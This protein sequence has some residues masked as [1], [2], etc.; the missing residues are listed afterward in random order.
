M[1]KP[2][3]LA[4][5]R[6]HQQ[7]IERASVRHRNRFFDDY[8]VPTIYDRDK[9][10]HVPHFFWK[11]GNFSQRSLE[12]LID[13]FG[14]DTASLQ[15]EAEL[16]INPLRFA[17][18]DPSKRKRGVASG[19]TPPGQRITNGGWMVF[20][21]EHDG[22]DA[23]SLE[24]QLDW[25]AGKPEECEFHK[26]HEAMST[27][28]D[29]RGYSTAFS[30]NKSLHIHLVFDTRHLSKEVAEKSKWANAMWQ[31]DVPDQVLQEL[32]RSTWLH[33]ATRVQKS[34]GVNIK[35]DDRLSTYIQKRR[36]PWGTRMFLAGEKPNIHGFQPGDFIEQ[37]VIQEHI[38]SRAPKGSIIT[39]LQAGSAKTIMEVER[40]SQ[41]KPSQ[42]IVTLGGEDLLLDELR[43]YLTECGWG[44]YPEP[45]RIEYLEPYNYVY[46]KNHAGDENPTTYVRGDYRM[47]APS[48]RDAHREQLFLPNNYTLDET[49]DVIQQRLDVRQVHPILSAKQQSKRPKKYTT[50]FGEGAVSRDTARGNLS[51]IL[52]N[53]ADASGTTLVQAPEGI[54]KTYALMQHV[55]ELRWDREADR[56]HRT[57]QRGDDTWSPIPGFICFACKSYEQANAKRD[58]FIEI[59]NGNTCA[60]VIKSLSKLYEE[61]AGELGIKP[62]KRKQAGANGSVSFLHAVKSMQP[63]VYNRMTELRDEMWMING[64][65]MFDPTHTVVFCV[66]SLLKNWPHSQISKAFLHPGF[67]DDFNQGGIKHC[68]REMGLYQ[69]IYDE[70]GWEDLVSIDSSEDV[71]AAKKVAKSV[72]KS[73]GKD[74]KDSGLPAQVEAYNLLLGHK[75]SPAIKFDDCNR[76]NQIGY[77]KRDKLK[78]DA[79]RFPFGKGTDEFNIYAKRSGTYYI[80]EHRW[81]SNLGCPVVILTTEDLPRCIASSITLAH[82]AE[83]QLKLAAGQKPHR[84]ESQYLRTMNLTDTPHLFNELVPVYFEKDARAPDKKGRTSVIDMAQDLLESG[85]DFVISN[86]LK[87]ID[88]KYEDQVCSHQAA[89]GRNDLT[90]MT[91]ATIITY[92]S[93]GEYDQLCILG[94]KFDLDD[95]VAMAM[96]DT[97][98]QDL[99]RNLGLRSTPGQKQDMHMVFIKSSLYRDLN[100]FQGATH[101]RYRLYHDYLLN[102]IS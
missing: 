23:A 69:V 80:K 30:G 67:P 76:I 15:S 44:Q 38:L 33:L 17:D 22:V 19:Y 35:F 74:W 75:K 8:I 28:S 98:F 2:S 95:P 53:V 78:V 7:Q 50:S 9:D 3:D 86:N 81:W 94:Q 88:K 49:L 87:K 24:M 21:F 6:K 97:L 13:E 40:H 42:R 57:T 66:H 73:T 85:I 61:A 14:D 48:G 102:G 46:F 51:G 96:R 92:P 36:S 79:K 100:L 70:V 26:V 29:Y 1:K 45:V 59:G 20:T 90:G 91:I 72:T 58:E 52:R 11:K 84:K 12:E 93:L 4:I 89:R 65:S 60:V 56:Q 101:D 10:V 63:A 71:K 16:F 31:G 83:D 54:G 43:L 68:I 25:F 62:I 47:V 34:L 39:L 55:Q 5:S 77:S 18:Y 32:Y 37:T 64:H 99:G 27:Y 82:R 41:S